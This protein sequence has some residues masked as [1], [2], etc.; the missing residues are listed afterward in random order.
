ME[1]LNLE[2]DKATF[3]KILVCF[4]VLIVIYMMLTMSSLLIF[5][6]YT[7]GA[8]T[9]VVEER[10]LNTHIDILEPE[11][12]KVEIAGWAY[13]EGES[14]GTV[15]SN[16]VLRHKETGKMYLMRTKMVENG[17]IQDE[18]Y[19]LAGMHAQCLLLGAPSGWYDILVLYQNAENDILTPTLIEVEIK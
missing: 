19:R 9:E 1:F 12:K 17:N 4:L 7:L 5:K 8:N 10:V 18:E 13:K 3:I 16:Y 14:L 2:I 11:G 15:N 6:S